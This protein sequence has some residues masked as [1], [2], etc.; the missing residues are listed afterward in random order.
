VLKQGPAGQ[1]QVVLV[2]RAANGRWQL[3]KGLVAAGESNEMAAVREVAEETGVHGRVVAPLGEL[4]Y[5]FM[6]DQRRIHKTVHF[7]LMQ[8]TGG[9]TA[10][11]DAEY[12]LVEW[13][14]LAEAERWLTFE[15]ERTM[16]RR[17]LTAWDQ[18]R[19]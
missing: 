12:D 2:G 17:A 15:S 5:W 4:S 1:R 3:P 7:F 13:F 19:S 14:D 11:H 8:Y 9:D 10:Q 16:L 18:H 6:A